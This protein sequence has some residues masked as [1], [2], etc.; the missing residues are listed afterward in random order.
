MNVPQFIK[1]DDPY[2][3]TM[4]VHPKS[5]VVGLY[6]LFGN[7]GHPGGSS[8]LGVSSGFLHVEVSHGETRTDIRA[9]KDS[10]QLV[11]MSWDKKQYSVFQATEMG[12]KKW[13]SGGRLPRSNMAPNTLWIGRY[14]T[15]SRLPKM[16]GMMKN[17]RIYNRALSAEEVKALYDLEKPK[18][19]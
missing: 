8:R 10:W 19:K 17:I 15:Y 9:L 13:H 18:A 6:E 11:C 14:A 3:F 4:W 1:S 5:D 16:E 7:V 2:T 12:V